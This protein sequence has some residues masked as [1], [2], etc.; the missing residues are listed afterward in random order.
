MNRRKILEWLFEVSKP[1]YISVFKHQSPWKV[2]RV[3]LLNMAKHKFGYHLGLF[4]LKNEFELIPKVE[5][6]DAYH[7]LTGFGTCV[8]DEIAL[9]YLVFGNGKRSLYTFSVL[10]LGTLLLPEYINFYSKSYKIG[11]EANVFHHL[12]YEL[13]LDVSMNDLQSSMFSSTLQIQMQL[14]L[15][16]L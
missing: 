2:T 10:I 12:N 11:K 3:Q 6:H 16:H 14:L 4:L 15:K 8:E 5:R 7:T 1:L 9:Q 13:L